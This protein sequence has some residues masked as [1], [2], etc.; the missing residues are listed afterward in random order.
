MCILLTNAAPSGTTKL[1]VAPATLAGAPATMLVYINSLRVTAEG[2]PG[3]MIVPFPNPTGAKDFGLVDATTTVAWRKAVVDAAPKFFKKE[4]Y[5]LNLSK[6]SR[7]A[8]I[9]Y[10]PVREVGN[11]RVSIAP[12]VDTLLQGIDWSRFKAPADLET[13]LAVLRDGAV[14]PC[15]G[16]AGFVV[17]EAIRSVKDDGFGIVFPGRHA[18]FPTC[19]EGAGR[20]LTDFDVDC[21][22][23]N[24]FM[25]GEAPLASVR[26]NLQEEDDANRLPTTLPLSRLG[27]EPC[28]SSATGLPMVLRLDPARSVAYASLKGRFTND[29][30]EGVVISQSNIVD[31]TTVTKCPQAEDRVRW[32]APLTSPSPFRGSGSTT[33]R[34]VVR[35]VHPMFTDIALEG[36]PA[37]G[38]GPKVPGWD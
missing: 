2:G 29:N 31:V 13:R 19:H 26:L 25:P 37:G 22:G 36:G 21:Y 18:F 14:M 27:A 24:M 28:V 15:G 9:A 35:A 23:V 5:S 6:D 17:A 32:T 1:F 4:A 33:G 30:L 20:A 10:E 11:Y 3:L 34:I 7:A 12:D 38:G 16:A 8:S